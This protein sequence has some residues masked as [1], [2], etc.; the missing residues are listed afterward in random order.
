[1]GLWGKNLRLA[2]NRSQSYLFCKMNK[3]MVHK[4]IVTSIV[5]CSVLERWTAGM[6]NA[7]THNIYYI[8][9]NVFI[10]RGRA[11][12]VPSLLKRGHHA[13]GT[14]S[15]CFI[16]NLAVKSSLMGQNINYAAHHVRT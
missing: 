15:S 1:M 14:G 9:A 16:G 7:M 12:V 5:N 6:V 10:V 3:Y 13:M 8:F 4:S 11:H 2:G